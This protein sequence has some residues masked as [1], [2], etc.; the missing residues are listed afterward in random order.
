MDLSW[1]QAREVAPVSPFFDLGSNRFARIFST[2][3]S[4]SVVTLSNA[5]FKSRYKMSPDFVITKSMNSAKFVA[6]EA[7]L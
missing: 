7:V 3:R 1:M 4:C 6:H 2:S 5:F